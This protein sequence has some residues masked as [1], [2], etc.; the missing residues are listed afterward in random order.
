MS[1][2]KQWRARRAATCDPECLGQGKARTQRMDLGLAVLSCLAV[3]GQCYSIDEIAAFAGV[4][5][6]VIYMYERKALK[7]LRTRLHVM[8][9]ARLR[10]C[11]VE[12]FERRSPAQ[13]TEVLA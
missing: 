1:A 9:D 8:K 4:P 5:F 13:R 10:D 7:K 12:Y 3:P 11:M 2:V 6:D